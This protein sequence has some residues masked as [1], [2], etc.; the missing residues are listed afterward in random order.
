MVAAMNANIW[1]VGDALEA[2]LR[3]RPPVD[4]ARLIDPDVDLVGL[5]AHSPD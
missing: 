5:A 3:A 2:L 4:E 1:D